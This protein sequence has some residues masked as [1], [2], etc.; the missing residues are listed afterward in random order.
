MG[1]I[2]EIFTSIQGEGLYIGEQHTFVRLAGC[3]LACDFCD[4]NAT[5]IS[6]PPTCRVETSPCTQNFIVKSNPMC[7]DDVLDIC[8][9]LKCSTISITGGEPLVQID[10]TYKL[11]EAMKANNFRTYLETN[12]TLPQYL[13]E[14]ISLCDIVAMDI[15]LQSTSGFPTKWDTHKN[16]LNIAFQ[17]E[18]IVKV[19]VS[20]KTTLDEVAHCCKLILDKSKSIPL[21][22]Q[23]DSNTDID[24][25]HYFKLQTEAL[26]YLDDVRVIPQCHKAMGIL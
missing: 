25:V 18:L 8:K 11:L 2:V 22:L 19:V 4:T 16:F 23:P 12:G 17:K 26:K 14:V 15:K 3:N 5:Q 1:W 7:V 21:I 6:D 24:M 13:E 9:S 20:N 10:F